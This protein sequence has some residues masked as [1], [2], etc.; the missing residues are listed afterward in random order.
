MVLCE[1]AK[2]L[3]S[4]NIPFIHLG[5]KSLFK[6]WGAKWLAS[7]DT[8][9]TIHRFGVGLLKRVTLRDHYFLWV[10]MCVRWVELWHN[11]CEEGKA[12]KNLVT[13]LR[14]PWT[15]PNLSKTSEYFQ[16]WETSLFVAFNYG[17]NHAILFKNNNSILKFIM[18]KEENGRIKKN[19]TVR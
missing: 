11:R 10:Y 3:S 19:R 8:K 12:R 2:L 9:R 4:M 14:R 13:N 6:K 17:G 15:K 7:F 16:S 18:L 5:L 1:K